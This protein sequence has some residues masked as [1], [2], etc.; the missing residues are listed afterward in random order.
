M[1]TNNVGIQGQVGAQAPNHDAFQE[2]DL[3]EFVK[4]LVAEMQNQD[5]MNP[6]ENQEILNQISQIRSIESTTRLTS[7]LDSVLL[8]QN[9]ATASSLI[10]K[11]I[12]GLTDSEKKINGTV[13]RVSIKDGVPTLHVGNDSVSL[14]N[15]SQIT[16]PA[17]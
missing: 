7:T 8:G 14:D 11:T 17:E 5:P 6:M 10:G 9:V 2:L 3:N 12:E 13:D 1:Q 15:V 16:P 4:M